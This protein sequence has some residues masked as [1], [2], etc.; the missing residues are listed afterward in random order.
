VRV[1]ERAEREQ[2][3]EKLKWEFAGNLDIKEN[4]FG[5]I[6]LSHSLSFRPISNCKLCSQ[7]VTGTKYRSE[8]DSLHPRKS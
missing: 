2:R 7:V 8:N 1:R 6:L 3:A 5:E 4:V